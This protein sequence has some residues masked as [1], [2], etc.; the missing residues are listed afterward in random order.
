MRLLVLRLGYSCG[1]FDALEAFG[2]QP[3]LR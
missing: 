1:D 3:V 2:A